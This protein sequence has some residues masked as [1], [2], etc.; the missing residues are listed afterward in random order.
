MAF[1][2][3]Y[4]FGVRELKRRILA[5][6]IGAPYLVRVQY[7]GWWGLSPDWKAGWREQQESAGGGVL[8]DYGSHLF[9]IARFLFGP[10]ECVTGFLHW[11]PRKQ[12][13][14]AYD[15]MIDVE[16]DDIAGAWFRHTSG[17]RGQW[18]VSR[19]TPHFADNGWLEVIGPE[20]AL[21]ASL[22]RGSIDCLQTSG[23][24]QSSWESLPLPAAASDGK[25]HALTAMMCSF[26]DSCI[27]GQSNPEVDATFID[28]MAA[29]QGLD[30]VMLANDR[31][32]WVSPSDISGDGSRPVTFYQSAH[33]PEVDDVR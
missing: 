22:S 28:G 25:P 24:K 9:D 23:P 32:V 6:D 19:A 15:L 1:T 5:G 29:Q 21:R 4:L 14:V 20:G 11:I 27:T 2:F 10:I 3:R 26:V 16:T 17:I 33:R 7:D 30:A 31:L 13:H 12:P 8:H 18:F